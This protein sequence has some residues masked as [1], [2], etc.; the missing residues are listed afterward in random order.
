MKNC[1]KKLTFRNFSKTDLRDADKSD[2]D[3]EDITALDESFRDD[4]IDCDA[5]YEGEDRSDSQLRDE[6]MENGNEEYMYYNHSDLDE[7]DFDHHVDVS[8]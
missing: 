3:R 6:E 4:D 1:W 8:I 5:D 2:S 7:Q